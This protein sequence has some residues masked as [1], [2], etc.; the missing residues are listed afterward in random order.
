MEGGHRFLALWELQ[1]EER[2]MKL[3]LVKR[4]HALW[5]PQRELRERKLRLKVDEPESRVGE[6]LGAAD[7]GQRVLALSEL[8][9]EERD[10]KL[11]LDADERASMMEGEELRVV[12]AG[13]RLQVLL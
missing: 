2:E 8:E 11:R 4:L 1:L 7:G 3:R 10:M 12:E 13:K 6:Q 5:E 9:R